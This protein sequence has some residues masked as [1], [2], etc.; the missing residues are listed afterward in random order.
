MKRFCIFTFALL[1]ISLSAQ[2]VSCLD[3]PKYL[4]AFEAI[5]ADSIN[6]DRNIR[7]SDW[8]IDLDRFWFKSHVKDDLYWNPVLQ[9]LV[10]FSWFEDFRSP[11]LYSAF[12]DINNFSESIVFFSLVEKNTLRADL[13]LDRRGL[14]NFRRLFDSVY[15]Y[16]F[17]FDE[18][19]NIVKQFRMELNYSPI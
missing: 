15:A 11:E 17:L 8:V 12:R 2:Q 6:S 9:S 4:K 3:I 14:H 10:K 1:S 18:E 16:L 13:F 19:G 5:R 7:V